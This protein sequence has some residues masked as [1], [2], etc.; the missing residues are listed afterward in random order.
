MSNARS[1]FTN[2]SIRQAY[3]TAAAT[4]YYYSSIKR[5]GVDT[6]V[7]SASSR[8]PTPVARSCI[9]SSIK[10]TVSH[11]V[12]YSCSNTFSSHI[13]VKH[14]SSGHCH[15]TFRITTFARCVCIS[16]ITT[17]RT[18]NLHKHA[19]HTAWNGECLNRASV[20]ERMC[21]GSATSAA[22]IISCS[23][24]GKNVI[25]KLTASRTFRG[26][27]LFERSVHNGGKTIQFIRSRNG[28][29]TILYGGRSRSHFCPNNR[30]SHRN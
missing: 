1:I 3:S 20:S 13:N 25:G 4:S 17:L 10:P 23:I 15:L 14:I 27:P 16:I 6:D 18:P 2:H 24:I 21:N 30:T 9:C 28:I 8:S 12:I 7:R 5:S 22:T 19:V 29:A 11:S 26:T